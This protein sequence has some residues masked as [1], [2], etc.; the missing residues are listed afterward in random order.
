MAPEMIALI[1]SGKIYNIVNKRPD[2]AENVR[3]FL[4][5]LFE[6]ACNFN[7]A[8]FPAPHDATTRAM[9]VKKEVEAI[10]AQIEEE[11][12]KAERNLR[13]IQSLY[14]ESSVLAN[15]IYMSGRDMGEGVGADNVT[16]KKNK[17]PEYERDDESDYEETN[18]EG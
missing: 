10:N 15:R 7:V 2:T 11:M 9:K 17:E 5:K 14:N 6:H 8:D 3:T 16:N 1:R 4:W 18:D 12:R 13:I